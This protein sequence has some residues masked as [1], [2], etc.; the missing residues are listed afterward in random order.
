M[1][2]VARGIHAHPDRGGYRQGQKGEPAKADGMD[3][4]DMGRSRILAAEEPDRA[5]PGPV[6]APQD[7]R[8]LSEL[9]Y[10]EVQK[11]TKTTYLV[12]DSL[13]SAG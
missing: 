3:P 6:P 4:Q 11:N 13:P 12:L 2:E 7:A 1:A 5:E 8:T 10:K 9:R